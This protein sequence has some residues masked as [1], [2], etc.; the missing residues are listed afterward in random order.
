MTF[1]KRILANG[2]A[3][4]YC[5]DSL[6]LLKAGV[7]GK[8]GAIVSDPPYG[9][10]YQHGGG[11]DGASGIRARDGS[12]LPS[13][14]SPIIGDDMPFDPVPWIDAAPR[15]DAY[16]GNA[17]LVLL[18]GA[19]H[20]KTRLPEGGTLLAWDKHLGRGPDDS[21]ADCEWAWC[22]RKPNARCSAGCGKVSSHKKHPPTGC[23]PML[24]TAKAPSAV[25][26]SAKSRWS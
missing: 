25:S 6:E 22:G 18:W 5:G 26:T 4:L 23:P 24:P 3:T 10:G 8:V 15:A 14:T 16:A 9:I 20:F 2:R 17:P 19:D 13:K 1:E 7:F 11:G 12:R 21:F